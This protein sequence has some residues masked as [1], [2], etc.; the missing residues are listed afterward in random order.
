MSL[1]P[2]VKRGRE[3]LFGA[4]PTVKCRVESYS[5]T[6]TAAEATLIYEFPADGTNGATAVTAR[7]TVTADGV[8]AA[9]HGTGEIAHALPVFTFDGEITP[10]LA[11]EARALTVTYDG[12]LCRYTADCPIEDTGRIAANRNG[13][14]AAYCA[15]SH[16]SLT[17]RIEIVRA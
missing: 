12:W 9:L 5:R 8:T 1:C 15:L 10:A 13:R 7:Y 17:V 2:A 11:E 4:D 14:Y 6:D 3:W 16:D